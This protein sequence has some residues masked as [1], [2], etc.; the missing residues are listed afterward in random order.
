MNILIDKVGPVTT[1]TINREQVRNAVDRPTA[2]ALADASREFEAGAKRF[3]S[4]HGRHGSK[5]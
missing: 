4:G 5:F 3:K 2:Q 1:L